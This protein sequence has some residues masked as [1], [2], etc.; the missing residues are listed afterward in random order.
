MKQWK[1]EKQG[2][3]TRARF[4]VGVNIR[5]TKLMQICIVNKI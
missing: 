5:R 4:R 1:P 3:V 2:N